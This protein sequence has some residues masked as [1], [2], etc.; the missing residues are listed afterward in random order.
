M[1]T[2]SVL[3]S[4]AVVCLGLVAYSYCAYP[5]CVLLW[6]AVK[7]VVSDGAYVLR[8]RDRR[9]ACMDRLPSVAVVVSAYNEEAHIGARIENLLAADYP[10]ELLRVYVGSDGSRDGTSA[11]IHAHEG[12][13][14][15]CFTFPD[16][17]G[18]ASVLND[19]IEGTDEEIL[20]FTDANSM[21]EPTS[22][23][24]LVAGFADPATGCV[25]GELRLA[26]GKGDNQDSVYWRVEQFLKFCESRIGGLLGANGAIYAIRRRLWQPLRADTICDDFTISM[27]IAATG[28]RLL[29]QPEAIAREVTP[30]A[31][32][33]EYRRR[34]RIG[35]GNFQVLARHP[36]F[37]FRTSFSTAFTYFSHK[38]LR[39]I[40]PHLIVLGLVASVLLSSTSTMWLV[41]SVL[42][43]AGLLLSATSFALTLRHREV[44][45]VLRIPAFL[46]ALNWGF[47]VASALYVTGR[48][49][50]SWQRSER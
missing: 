13:R 39:W 5:I 45:R 31:I 41:S 11:V 40:T 26:G 14:V 23:R 49:R 27:R 1:D 32:R 24:F 19:L 36:D 15:R 44:P 48:Y 22:I 7:Q 8:K 37:L 43:S 38:V 12:P 25:C 9:A 17:R 3:E 20:V 6:A 10:R 34:I 16:N 29:Y 46:F 50:G 18:K 47:M 33:E 35:I 42:L 4:L 2:E 21:F 30:G 28:L